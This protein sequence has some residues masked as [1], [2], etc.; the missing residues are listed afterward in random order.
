MEDG[1]TDIIASLTDKK[2]KILSNKEFKKLRKGVKKLMKDVELYKSVAD[3][4]FKWYETW[5][6]VATFPI[7]ATIQLNDVFKGIE[8]RKKQEELRQAKRDE[9]IK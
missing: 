1:L 8:A 6:N 3:D 5:K 2:A 7:N 4:F 9:I